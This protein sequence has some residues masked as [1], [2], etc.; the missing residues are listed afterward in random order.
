VVLA[1]VGLLCSFLYRAGRRPPGEE[2]LPLPE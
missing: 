1:A 2:R